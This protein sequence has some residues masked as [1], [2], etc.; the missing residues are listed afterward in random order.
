MCGVVGI[1]NVSEP[2]V[3]ALHKV[4][5]MVTK[6]RQ[7]SDEQG[8]CQNDCPPGRSVE[9]HKPHSTNAAKIIKC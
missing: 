7:L 4:L 6:I 5:R 1:F 9:E 2:V 8:F 3:Q